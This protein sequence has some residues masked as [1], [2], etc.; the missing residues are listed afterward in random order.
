MTA[1]PPPRPGLPE[2]YGHHNT[3]PVPE[4]LPWLRRLPRPNAGSSLLRGA[5]QTILREPS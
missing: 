1:S 5:R 2:L 3:S 4:S